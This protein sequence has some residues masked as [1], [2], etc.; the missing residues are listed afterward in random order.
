LLDPALNE[1]WRLRFILHVSIVAEAL[2]GAGIRWLSEYSS[3]D[4]DHER[5]GI[6]VCVVQ[7]WEL[8]MRIGRLLRPVF[9][10]WAC[11][12]WY[13]DYGIEQGWIIEIRRCGR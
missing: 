3:L 6:E 4:P 8:A 2:E 11:F 5:Y 13:K 7:D 1:P 12:V 9:P 10:D